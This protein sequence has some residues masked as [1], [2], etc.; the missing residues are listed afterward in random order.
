[1]GKFEVKSAGTYEETVKKEAVNNLSIMFH[2][3]K[4]AALA[5]LFLNVVE[6]VTFRSM[7]SPK[8]EQFDSCSTSCHRKGAFR[9]M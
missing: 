2:V 7:M 9:S 6:K 8:G 4:L 5:F 1:M 3:S